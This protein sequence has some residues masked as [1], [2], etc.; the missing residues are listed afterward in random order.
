MAAGDYTLGVRGQMRPYLFESYDVELNGQTAVAVKTGFR[1]VKHAIVTTQE[2]LTN[3]SYQV[4]VY[5]IS[6]GTVNVKCT[7]ADTT[8]T[9]SLLVLGYN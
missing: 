8:S 5:S 9:V 2:E 7:H 3:P 4:Y 6:G 1:T